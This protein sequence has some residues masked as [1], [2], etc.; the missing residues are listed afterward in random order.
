MLGFKLVMHL[1]ISNSSDLAVFCPGSQLA[2]NSDSCGTNQPGESPGCKLCESEQ[3][4]S[5]T[6][7]ISDSSFALLMS[8][9]Y[10][11]RFQG[12]L[13]SALPLP[14]LPTSVLNSETL[15]CIARAGKA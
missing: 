12:Q 13:T 8:F 3:L 6:A 15:G 7:T 10:Y 5:L 1:P 14:Q 2:A 11:K 9:A 4:N